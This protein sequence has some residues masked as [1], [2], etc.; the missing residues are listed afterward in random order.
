MKEAATIKARRLASPWRRPVRA[1]R[2]ERK[3]RLAFGALERRGLQQDY[4]QSV[5]SSILSYY[6]SQN[7]SRVASL[8]RGKLC[9]QAEVDARVAY[10]IATA[11]ADYAF[12]LAEID[13][14]EF[15][16][17]M[18]L[19]LLAIWSRYVINQNWTYDTIKY[20]G[21]DSLTYSMIE[22][23]HT[24]NIATAAF[25]GGAVTTIPTAT[26][27]D[28]VT[29]E[30]FSGTSPTQIANMSL[31]TDAL[32]WFGYNAYTLWSAFQNLNGALQSM[33]IK[34]AELEA[35]SSKATAKSAYVSTYTTLY[36]AEAAAQLNDHDAALVAEHNAEKTLHL[37]LMN[38]TETAY[39]GELNA[40]VTNDATSAFVDY[41]NASI[42]H[43]LTYAR[44]AAS[45]FGDLQIGNRQGRGA[46]EVAWATNMKSLRNQYMTSATSALGDY[47]A[48]LTDAYSD[49]VSAAFSALTTA[50]SSYF[51]AFKTYSINALNEDSDYVHALYVAGK[52]RALARLDALIAELTANYAKEA[53]LTGSRSDAY[54][55]K[56]GAA[57][58]CVYS[59]QFAEYRRG[60]SVT[61]ATYS[62]RN[63]Y[64]DGI[65]SAS[66]QI[67]ALKNAA[68]SEDASLATQNEATLTATKSANEA[69]RENAEA[70]ADDAYSLTVENAWKDA[71]LAQL[72]LGV[73]LKDAYEATAATFNGALDAAAGDLRDAAFAAWDELDAEFEEY[74]RI[75]N[76][77]DMRANL[78][79]TV[80][81]DAFEDPIFFDF[82]VCFVAGTPILMAD[83]SKKPIE[84]IQPGDVVLAADH[85]SPEGTPAP[86]C[87]I[88]TRNTIRSRE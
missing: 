35:E 27:L 60:Y 18:K 38:A 64:F 50:E 33:S 7:S 25:Y 5:K 80:P 66:N 81:A 75:L 61:T 1:P 6:Q 40:I 65:V 4:A 17:S 73:T 19:D 57:Q 23:N 39:N 21:Y 2:S 46:S 32:M 37:A 9:D 88:M 62:E 76:Y 36:G 74:A 42:G 58:G 85:L 16:L 71:Y 10:Y 72:A 56:T 53:E 86:A 87:V 34:N 41:L 59:T 44:T 29:I 47:A 13:A 22:P 52:T 68:D 24:Y 15:A 79:L 70:A 77:Q 30:G 78:G 43:A 8:T 82:E 31:A 48:S 54:V 67:V 20:G 45:A 63:A 55:Q 12:N 26:S 49:Y 3:R 69:T 14:K 51:N 28:T 84:E 11:D 83:G